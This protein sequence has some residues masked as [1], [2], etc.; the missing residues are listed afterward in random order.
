MGASYILC[1]VETARRS[2]GVFFQWRDAELL[3]AVDTWYW[4]H[5]SSCTETPDGPS[6][7]LLTYSWHNS[8]FKWLYVVSMNLRSRR[9][10]K[11]VINFSEEDWKYVHTMYGQYL[12]IFI[13]IIIENYPFRIAVK[14]HWWAAINRRTNQTSC[15]NHNRLLLYDP[16]GL[17]IRERFSYRVHRSREEKK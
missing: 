8:W 2:E 7:E 14:Q 1:I 6:D 11:S 5:R 16:L 4:R 15:R 12:P 13:Y 3:M 17:S 10:V 9:D